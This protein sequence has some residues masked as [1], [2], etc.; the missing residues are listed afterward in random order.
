MN[1]FAVALV[2]LQICGSGQYLYQGKT[3]LGMLWF[4]YAT[5]NIVL[6]RMGMK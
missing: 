1:W 3:D 5:A 6:I 4:L 2:V